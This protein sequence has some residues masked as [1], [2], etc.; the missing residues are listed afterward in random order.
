MAHNNNNHIA[1]DYGEEDNSNNNNRP[2]IN[3]N[4]E[5]GERGR[6]FDGEEDDTDVLNDKNNDDIIEMEDG[7]YSSSSC[8]SIN[9]DTT[10][11]TT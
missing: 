10:F 4:H 7:G 9:I 1:D 5:V 2:P 6:D 8:T 3:S 11:I